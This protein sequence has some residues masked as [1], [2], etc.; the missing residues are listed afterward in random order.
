M[1]INFMFMANNVDPEN[2]VKF[3]YYFD[4]D[5]TNANKIIMFIG[6]S[7]TYHELKPEIGWNQQNGMAASDIEHDYV[8]L[9]LSHL[10]EKEPS[11]AAIVFNAGHWELDFNNES[12][13][14]TI[15]DVIK[16][17]KPNTVVFRIGENSQR[18]IVQQKMDPKPAYDNLIKEIS[19]NCDD[20]IVTSL[21]WEYPTLDKILKDAAIENNAKYVLINDL[22]YEDENKAIGLYEHPGV[23]GHPGNLGMKRIAERIISKLNN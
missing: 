10:R 5:I 4:G 3:P 15:M 6:N 2:Q 7:I 13:L 19:N 18:P 21:F 22:G 11:T 14:K 1:S 8:H 17:Y 16:Q 9:V 20:V 23:Q 12:K